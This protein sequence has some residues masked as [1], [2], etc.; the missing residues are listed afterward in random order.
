MSGLMSTV[1][2][3][4]REAHQA[5]A[6][7]T[8]LSGGLPVACAFVGGFGRVSFRYIWQVKCPD[9]RLDKRRL[10]VIDW[11]PHFFSSVG[12]VASTMQDAPAPSI[13]SAKAENE[14]AR[15]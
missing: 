1:V 5:L 13:N 6:S 11:E 9:G 14:N 12:A 7:Y 4:P 8:P 10:S 15:I 3:D 2:A